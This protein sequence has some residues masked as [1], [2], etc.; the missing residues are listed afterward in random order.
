M[1]ERISNNDAGTSNEMHSEE[2]SGDNEF[3]CNEENLPTCSRQEESE[4]AMAEKKLFYCSQCGKE[5]TQKGHLKIHERIHTGEKPFACS[6][7]GKAFSVSSSL[8]IHE[9]IHT[10]EKPF[11]C[12]KCGTAFN[13]RDSLKLHERTHPHRRRDIYLLKM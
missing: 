12:S 10:G 6:K 2:H 4:R 3:N 11:A 5:F 7:C 9:R 1:M 8:K 13:R